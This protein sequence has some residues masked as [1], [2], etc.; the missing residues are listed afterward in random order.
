M[1]G[2][3]AAAAWVPAKELIATTRQLSVLVHAGIPL[4]RSLGILGEQTEVAA[5][6]RILADLQKRVEGGARFSEVLAR[7][8]TVFSELFV[9]SVAAAEVG[10]GMDRVL[11]RLVTMMERDYEVTREVKAALQYPV[12]L[13]GAIVGAVLFLMWFVVP[14]FAAIY[15][16]F[17]TELPLLTRLL[18]AG[19][20]FLSQGWLVYLPVTVAV[21]VSWRWYIGTKR[22]RFQWDRA[23]LYLPVFGP[24]L[25]QMVMARFASMLVFLYSSGL[26]ILRCLEV[27]SRAVGN[28]AAGQQIG[29]LERSVREGRGLTGGLEKGR[30][31]PPLLRHMVAV[32]ESSGKLQELLESVVSY[33][34]MEVRNT[35]KGLSGLIE[36]ILTLLLGVVILTL[37]LAVFLPM[38]NLT[39]VFKKG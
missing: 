13:L 35:T 8:P 19:S 14:R 18:I 26:P 7:Y 28:V 21:V 17:K 32:G 20:R 31:F 16:R 34:D 4:V 30:F 2:R 24:L 15:S 27:V 11:L 3:P 22:G 6:K 38:W 39:Q 5:L 36:P 33:Y 23:K 12:M 29:L 1:P 10:G 9:N 37:A 25:R